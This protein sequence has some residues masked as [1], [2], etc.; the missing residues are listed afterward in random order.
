MFSKKTL[1]YIWLAYRAILVFFMGGCGVGVLLSIANGEEHSVIGAGFAAILMIIIA[2][3]VAVVRVTRVSTVQAI[4]LGDP[5]TRGSAPP[6]DRNSPCPCGS[7][8]KYKHCCLPKIE[9]AEIQ[10]AEDIN[11]QFPDR[12]ISIYGDRATREGHAGPVWFLKAMK[13]FYDRTHGRNGKL[14]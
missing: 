6:P 10:Y 9:A 7:G 5:R 4:H 1:H 13:W 12:L 8:R 11:W 14:N 3:M 2:V